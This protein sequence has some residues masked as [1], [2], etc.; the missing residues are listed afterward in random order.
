MTEQDRHPAAPARR[1]RIA[2][3]TGRR[4]TEY[5]PLLEP[6]MRTVRQLSLIHI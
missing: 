2:R 5:S 1:G 3:L 6:L 4:A